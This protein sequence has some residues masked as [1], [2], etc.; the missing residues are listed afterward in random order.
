MF[1]IDDILSR[2]LDIDINELKKLVKH[3]KDY[4]ETP[5][6]SET[7]QSHTHY[8]WKSLVLLPQYIG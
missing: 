5:T 4:I 7:K 2:A 8:F 1:F 3:V 6:R